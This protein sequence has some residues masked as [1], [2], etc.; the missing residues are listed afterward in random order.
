MRLRA[1]APTHRPAARGG[2]EES[3]LDAASA[4]QSR[5]GNRAF[6]DLVARNPVPTV[7]RWIF[8]AGTQVGRRDARLDATTRP[9]ARDRK[10][11][12]Y[13]DDAEMNAHASGTTDYLGH[14]PGPTSRNTWVR[15][16]PTGVNLLGENHTQVTLEQVAPAV[17]STN[18]TY[19]PFSRDVV[20]GAT[21]TAMDT[22]TSGRM[23]RMGVG[24]GNQRDHG[25]E[26]VFPKLAYNMEALTPYFSGASPVSELRRR[27]GYFGQP[28]QRYLKV[29]WAHA[30]DVAL[31]V[32]MLQ[33]TA[34]AVPP[35]KQA[36]ATVVA[37]HRAALEP[38]ITGLAVDGWLGDTLD[39]RRNRALLPALLDLANAFM[40]VMIARAG[41]DPGLSSAQQT[42]L[43]GMPTG[44]HAERGAMFSAWRNMHFEQALTDAVAN[45]VRYQGMGMAHLA[46]LQS[47]GLPG[48]THPFDM[49]A[50]DIQGFE[51]ATAR[52]RR[53][54]R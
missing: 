54:A 21:A 4:L 22:E 12:D 37:N 19:E 48:G 2:P 40:P 51:R 1:T 31:E 44:T 24:G 8:I 17:G 3:S 23:T 42:A 34:Q 38:Y 36:L 45:G 9:L 32:A 29:T 10:V 18:F 27:N 11:R 39:T 6:G 7:Q 33:A 16:S 43:G 28:A 35:A 5:I 41:A 50:A 13:V 52:L 53:I 14:L 20:G 47:Q 30:K 49:T 26:S 15:F 25:G 46:H